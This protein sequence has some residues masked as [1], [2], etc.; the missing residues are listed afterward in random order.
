MSILFEYSNLWIALV[1]IL[2][3]LAAFILYRK[4]RIVGHFTTPV[5][6]LL[7]I[8]RFLTL[9]LL[10]LLLL[11][12]LVRT[13]ETESEQ[14]IVVIAQDDSQSLVMGK[15][16]DFVKT[17][18]LE[19]L[20]SL[21]Q[22]LSENY[23]V[24]TFRYGNTIREGLD[25]IDFDQK[26]TDFS[27]LQDA[28]FTRYSH[29]NL[30]AVIVGS[31]GLY[32]KGQSP[33]YNAKKLNAPFYT[34][35]LG[36]T[37]EKKDLKILDVAHNRLAYLGN[38]FPL[39]I[40]VEAKK[41]GNEA[42]KVTVERNGSILFSGKFNPANDGNRKIFPVQL[43][44][45]STGLQRYTV[46]ISRLNDE[47]TY[48]NNRKDIFIDVLD[49]RQKI[50]ILASSPHP[51]VAALKSAIE[52]NK[53]YEVYSKLVQEFKGK[54]DD[55]SLVVLHQLPGSNGQQNQT[56]QSFIDAKVPALFITGAQTNFNN[57]N[58]LNLG[59]KL[60]GFT[61]NIN[62]IN[63]YVAKGFSE[64]QVSED[65]KEMFTYFPPL[66]VPFGEFESSPGISQLLYQRVGNIQTD[67][68]LLSFNKQGQHPVGVLAGEGIW[69]WRM[70]E[71]LNSDSHGNF[72]QFMS[73]IVQYL[74]SKD[75]K[76][77]FRVT[78][79]TNLLENQA[80]I[81][82]A[83]VYNAS[84]ESVS[85][86]D[87]NMIIKDSEGIEYPFVFSSDGANYR[88]DAGKLP[89]NNYN[90]EAKVTVGGR[91][92]VERG[93]FSIA[94]VQLEALNLKADHQ[95]LNLLAVQ[96]GGEL[97]YPD[98]VTSLVQAIENNADV[99]TLS[100]EKKSLLDLIELKWF[101][102]I[103]LILLGAEWMIRKF[104]GAY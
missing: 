25:S 91:I 59:Y 88:L 30:G 28:L 66:Q 54:A 18:Y 38:L 67:I 57:F 75:D 20:R 79:Q 90:W 82:K 101:L 63:A 64:F 87:I 60:E 92:F 81:F 69:R 23:E 103:F 80:I 45:K 48:D 31:D 16:S 33:L 47:I 58:K 13:V 42:A 78:A 4:D 89:V 19:K 14:P 3:F 72:N 70:V 76:R 32:N 26:T 95:M 29:R 56:V 24:H 41:V 65:Q 46:K 34:I 6:W 102:F 12:P 96:N 93:E 8:L 37:V 100:Y 68:P 5:K 50:L 73:K 35:A 10:G 36:D 49:S 1:A 15:D 11:K 104:L 98:Q 2:A 84:Y 77:Q 17:A 9:F 83:E 85:G 97:V 86:A 27:K 55:Y 7:G 51:D 74:A 94:P 39:E 22:A 61:G 40:S 44:A 53:N 71:Y 62:D 99:V 21:E 43:E 52:S